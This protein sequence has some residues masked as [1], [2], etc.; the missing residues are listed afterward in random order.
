MGWTGYESEMDAGMLFLKMYC[1]KCGTRLKKQKVV[2][3]FSK[4]EEEFRNHL[5]G[6]TTIGMTK[7]KKVHYVYK[8]PTCQDIITY[9]E[10]KKIRKIQKKLNRKILG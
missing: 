2:N 5:L 4:G 8:C 7:I 1:S 3:I 10:Q 6:K 9:D